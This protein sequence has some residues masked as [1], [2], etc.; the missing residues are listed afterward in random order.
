MP[1]LG[2]WE[3]R[4]QESQIGLE[5]FSNVEKDHGTVMNV[6]LCM[7]VGVRDGIEL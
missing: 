6:Y 2:S 4:E 7:S 1:M 3:A 5:E